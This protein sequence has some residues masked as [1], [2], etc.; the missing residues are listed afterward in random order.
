MFWRI[1]LVLQEPM[2]GGSPH[3]FGSIELK[4][5]LS[6]N[7]REQVSA[8]G[9]FLALRNRSFRERGDYGPKLAKVLLTRLI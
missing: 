2:R 9:K 1:G 7:A 4:L 3:Q 6:A 8:T 5:N